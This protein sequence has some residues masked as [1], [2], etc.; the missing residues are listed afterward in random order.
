MKRRNFIGLTALGAAGFSSGE[1]VPA[2]RPADVYL[3]AG[4]SNM[5]GTGVIAELPADA[6]KPAA[7]ALFWTGAKFEPLIPG[8]TP[9]A[10]TPGR[11]GPEITFA[12]SMAARNPARDVL[13]VKFALSGQPLHH[14]WDG[15][16]WA[17]SPPAPNRANFHPGESAQDPNTGRHYRAMMA[18]LGKALADLRSR[19]ADFAL[20]GIVWMQGEQDAKHPESAVSYALNLA[21]LKRRIESD[22]GAAPVPLVFGQVLPHDP[23]LPRFTHRAE[24]RL[25]QAHADARS[26]HADAIPLARMI[27]TDGL[28]LN[29]D[30]VHY[31]SA[32]LST[33]GRLFADACASLRP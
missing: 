32:G 29:G 16:R 6:A 25:A 20:R 4:Q 30:T 21:R 15:P 5:Q 27:S 8:Q 10:G 1:P 9:T 26:G 17:G 19:K 2:G 7:N 28:P 18:V 24:I 13:T 3:L 22:A 33:L 23:P 11:F 12:Q 31:T 14:G